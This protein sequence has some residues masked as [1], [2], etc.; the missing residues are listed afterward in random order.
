MDTVVEPDYKKVAAMSNT[1]RLGEEEKDTANK[2]DMG[3]GVEWTVLKHFTSSSSFSESCS[4]DML[5]PKLVMKHWEQESF[6]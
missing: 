1:I 5:L 3:S 4:S 2:G 6:E